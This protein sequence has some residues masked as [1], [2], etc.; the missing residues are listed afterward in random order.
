VLR[1]VTL[2]GAI[3][4]RHADGDAPPRLHTAAFTGG[5]V[6]LALGLVAWAIA[7]G[8]SSLSDL[9]VAVD[10]TVGGTLLT[11]GSLLGRARAAEARREAQLRVLGQ[12]AR[13]MSAGPGSEDVGCAV[14]E[15][16][17]RVIQYHNAR[18][19]LLQG[20]DDL[21]PVAFEGT[22]GAYER[23]DLEILR[24]TVGVGFTGWVA[25]FGTAIRVD[26]A[27]SDP[28]GAT[29][30]GTDDVDES[31]LVVPMRHEETLLGVITLSKLGLRQFDDDDLRLL[32]ILADQAATAFAG[33]SHL[34]ETRRLT[35][36]LRQL[37]DMSSSLSR[38]LDPKA[39]ADLIAFHLASAVG[40]DRAQISDWDRSADRLRTLGCYP[41][42]LRTTLADFYP[43]DGFPC[44]A[45]V[46]TSG[47]LAVI[48]VDDPD[49]DRAE[50]A[51]LTSEDMRGLVM[52]PL[53]AKG[54]AIGLVELVSRD[55]PT[56]DP[57]RI[58]LARTMAHEAAMALENAR[59]Y[60]TARN[61]A[62]RDPLT[63]FFNHRYLHE[64][65]SEE[66]VRA[67][68]TRRPLSVVMIDLDDFKLVN[69]TFG[70]VYGDRVLVYVAETIRAT[71]RESDVA[72][73]YGGDE[74]ALVLPETGADDATRVAERILEAFHA[75][76]FMVDGRD[77]FPVGASIGIATHP[78]D[79]R[80]AT[81]LVQAADALL[82][83]AKDAGGNRVLVGDEGDGGAVPEVAGA[84]LAAALL[85][86]RSLVP[87]R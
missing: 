15:E 87:R 81:D 57:G 35:A 79:G 63:G 44:T 58:T 27:R 11:T 24:T 45:E 12:A 67:V 56:A 18:V 60:E 29:I 80:S 69:D 19:Y 28:R 26:D 13:R 74:F 49:A 84:A 17:R 39:V 9:I 25:R 73:R 48:D 36:E 20:A 4:L 50:V 61:L 72:A 76:P 62:D 30:P 41:T 54:E 32:T 68:R 83:L 1:S 38:S 5:L 42:K 71:L 70:H 3:R 10:L 37:L 6:T 21:V 8:P 2:P 85:G 52:L 31:M 16:I 46:L 23:V 82:Y 86:T 34:A 43:L 66:V 55:R 64:R 65:L 78:R 51:L 22:V 53:I 33:A 77:Q 47:T 40:A 14:V 59:M 75:A 7:G